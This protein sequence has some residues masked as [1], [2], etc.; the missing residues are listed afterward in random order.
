MTEDVQAEE[1]GMNDV[2]AL[3]TVKDLAGYLRIPVQTIYQWRTKGY[4]PPGHRIGK[5]VRYLPDEVREWITR[6]HGDPG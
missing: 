1:G 3:W 6:L 4:G 5:H 2:D